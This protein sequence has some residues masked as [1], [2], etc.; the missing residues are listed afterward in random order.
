MAVGDRVGAATPRKT[1]MEPASGPAL[2]SLQRPW[3]SLKVFAFDPSRGRSPS[4]IVTLQVP[5]EPLKPGPVG[6]SVAVVDSTF[7]LVKL[8]STEITLRG[9]LD[10][11]EV[12]FQFHQQMVYAVAMRTIADFE[13]GL[14]R[15]VQWPW[16]KGRN[17]IQDRLRLLPHGVRFLNAYF[18]PEKGAITFGYSTPF[19]PGLPPE[20]RYSREQCI[21]IDRLDEMHLEPGP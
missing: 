17:R 16:D 4:N 11:S 18:E 14:E 3:R 1:A 13:R 20:H 15:P 2:R 9:G 21:R 19:S 6:R 12:D 5:Y 8:D 7:D 10:P